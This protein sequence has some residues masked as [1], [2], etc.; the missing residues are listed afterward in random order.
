[1]RYRYACTCGVVVCIYACLC[2]VDARSTLA[3]RSRQ[4]DKR[5][6]KQ[7]NDRPFLLVGGGFRFVLDKGK[8]KC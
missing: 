1:M 8:S 3:I 4:I 5:L 6:L 7:G 2:G